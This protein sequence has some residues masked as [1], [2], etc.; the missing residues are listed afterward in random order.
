MFFF[1]RSLQN[2]GLLFLSKKHAGEPQRQL[3]PLSHCTHV[4]LSWACVRRLLGFLFFFFFFISEY[5][6]RA[7]P[8]LKPSRCAR[9][10]GLRLLLL[11]DFM[12]W[13]WDGESGR[14]VEWADAINGKFERK[15]EHVGGGRHCFLLSRRCFPA[16]VWERG[17]TAVWRLFL[18]AA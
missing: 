18:S 8:Q 14:W 5:N 16:A 12:T 11:P 7:W 2:C 1:F 10:R 15:D 13:C 17:N 4:C 3:Q 6:L 9:L